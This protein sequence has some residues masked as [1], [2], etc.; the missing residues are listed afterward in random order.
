MCIGCLATADQQCAETGTTADPK[1]GA[2]FL[3]SG[4]EEGGGTVTDL[5]SRCL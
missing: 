1:A 2:L 5:S 3:G 4:E